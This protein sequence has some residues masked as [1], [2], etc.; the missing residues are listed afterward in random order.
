MGLLKVCLKMFLLKPNTI[1]SNYKVK[2]TYIC[3]FCLVK[4][5]GGKTLF[6]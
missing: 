3:V 2:G 4:A 1:F 6:F 5:I